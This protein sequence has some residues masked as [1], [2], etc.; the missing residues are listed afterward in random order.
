MYNASSDK[1][2]AK[3]DNFKG[4]LHFAIL[5]AAES[6]DKLY[7]VTT[8]LL[9]ALYNSRIFFSLD[10]E[11]ESLK[12]HL[13]D[14]LDYALLPTEGWE[15]LASWYG[16]RDGQSAIARKVVEHG[17]FVKHCKVEVYLV[18]LKLCRNS[19]M[20]T[21]QIRPFSRADNVGWYTQ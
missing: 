17:M 12:S 20:E 13:I 18:E 11:C 7:S 10:N 21:Y 1:N 3:L 16:L 5:R 4:L 2:C 14:E 15:K 8:A 9:Y 19:D 6:R